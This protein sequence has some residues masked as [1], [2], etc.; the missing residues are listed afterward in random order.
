M[1]TLDPVRTIVRVNLTTTADFARDLATLVKTEYG[2]VMLA[3]TES[4]VQCAELS[5]YQV[6]ALIETAV[7]IHYLAEIAAVP[8]VVGLMWGAEDLVASLGGTPSRHLDG[9]YRDV[10]KQARSSVLIAAGAHGKAAIDAVYVNIP[11][12]EA[13]ASGLTATACIHPS[14]VEVIRGVYLPSDETLM[15]ARR[16]LAA[17]EGEHGVFQLDGRVI[18][19]PILKHA[20]WALLRADPAR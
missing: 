5:R 10:A 20:E 3:K 4:A 12:A 2:T 14:Q 18:D 16:V 9:T 1:S 19:A 8:S 11:D 7:G 13:A 15:W 17:A 6:I